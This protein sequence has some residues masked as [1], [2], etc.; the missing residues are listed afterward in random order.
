LKISDGWPNDGPDD[1]ASG[2]WAGVVLEGPR[3]RSILPAPDLNVVSE[4][5]VS[6]RA[7]AH[8]AS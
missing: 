8:P 4:V 2:V 7:L 6:V 5:P 3:L 1:Q